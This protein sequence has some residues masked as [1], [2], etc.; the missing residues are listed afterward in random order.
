[1]RVNQ[2]PIVRP[3]RERRDRVVHVNARREF[4]A[5]THLEGLNRG[6]RYAAF[7]LVSL[8]QWP[9]PQLDAG[10][11][12]GHGQRQ[13]VARIWVESNRRAERCGFERSILSE[14]QLLLLKADGRTNTLHPSQSA[15]TQKHFSGF[16][17]RR[18]ASA[19]PSTEARIL[20]RSDPASFLVEVLRAANKA[21]AVGDR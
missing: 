1:M 7:S 15:W 10:T 17:S 16:T 3:H 11:D 8:D 19:L 20:V 13:R 5:L 2:R 4:E 14:L 21:I 18:L 6:W 12:C 9:G